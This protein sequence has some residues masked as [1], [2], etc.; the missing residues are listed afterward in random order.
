MNPINFGTVCFHLHLSQHAVIFLLTFFFE[1]F[2][3]QESVIKFPHIYEL[4]NFSPVID[5]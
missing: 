5:T 2:S 3:V 1:L 4:Y